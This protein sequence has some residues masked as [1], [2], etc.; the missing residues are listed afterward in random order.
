[1]NCKEHGKTIVKMLQEGVDSL[2][3]SGCG[4][5][6]RVPMHIRRANSKLEFDNTLFLNNLKSE[7]APRRNGK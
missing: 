6:V 2:P 4:E 5:E 7:L 1:M 3:C